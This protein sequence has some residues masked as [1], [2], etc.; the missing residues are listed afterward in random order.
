MEIHTQTIK[1]D[2]K[3]TILSDKLQV[4]FQNPQDKANFQAMISELGIED[5]PQDQ[6]YLLEAMCFAGVNYTVD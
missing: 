4:E 6:L 2:G 3:Q 1:S 5:A